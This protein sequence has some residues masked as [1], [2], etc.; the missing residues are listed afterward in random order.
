MKFAFAVTCT[1][2]LLIS[3]SS[4]ICSHRFMVGRELKPKAVWTTRLHAGFGKQAQTT[5]SPTF[6]KCPCGSQKGYNECC[7]TAHI[8]MEGEST[9][10]FLDEIAYLV[11]LHLF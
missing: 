11:K 9:I 5:S 2:I 4:Y 3:C 1:C 7:S 10:T 6:D 8:L